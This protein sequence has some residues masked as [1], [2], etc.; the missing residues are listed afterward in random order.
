ML[1][2]DN[3]YKIHTIHRTWAQAKARCAMEG[4]K[5]FYPQDANESEG[6][7]SFLTET[8]PFKEVVIGISDTL[9]TGVY[10]TIDGEF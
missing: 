6:V 7:L 4:A 2:V 1:V 10:E 9:S 5:L 8:Q 3:F